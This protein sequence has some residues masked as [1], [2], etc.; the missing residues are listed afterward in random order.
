MENPKK[1]KKQQRRQRQ[2]KKKS[3][4]SQSKKKKKKKGDPAAGTS[5][6]VDIALATDIEFSINL[7]QKIRETDE[8]RDQR[9]KDK[10][11]WSQIPRPTTFRVRRYPVCTAAYPEEQEM[12]PPK[13]DTEAL[14]SWPAIGHTVTYIYGVH[15][16]DLGRVFKRRA[17]RKNIML[18]VVS[19]VGG[20]A[21]VDL[22]FPPLSRKDF[23]HMVDHEYEGSE[24]VLSL[25]EKN[26]GDEA[27]L[28]R[29][30]EI[31]AMVSNR[32]RKG[33][34]LDKIVPVWFL[35]W[36]FHWDH[37]RPNFLNFNSKFGVCSGIADKMRNK[38]STALGSLSGEG[39]SSHD[40]ELLNQSRRVTK[41]MEIV[42]ARNDLSLIQ[43]RTRDL[44]SVELACRRLFKPRFHPRQLRSPAP[45]Y[46][47][48]EEVEPPQAKEPSPSS[49]SSKEQDPL[50][51]YVED[52]QDELYTEIFILEKKVSRNKAD[53]RVVAKELQNMRLREIRMSRSP[54]FS[55]SPSFYSL[56]NSYSDLP[57]VSGE[58]D[59]DDDFH[60]E[61]ESIH[62]QR[63]QQQQQHEVPQAGT[64]PSS[65]SSDSSDSDDDDST[66]SETEREVERQRKRKRSEKKKKKKKKKEKI[67]RTDDPLRKTG[68]RS[69][70][71]RL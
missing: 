48:A 49:S 4:K 57:L 5:T 32:T 20:R 29:K 10:K 62:Y 31:V 13:G 24:D 17:S 59:D 39:N 3:G 37:V 68:R 1:G 64:P 30:K 67:F 58:D 41:S 23:Q 15:I 9:T 11:S 69:K 25:L 43:G 65:S 66:D 56:H 22:V 55:D 63:Q 7:P 54:S 45:E 44:I 6:M 46:E 36:M 60:E 33:W 19:K 12:P 53:L 40:R 51:K 42:A 26:K 38:M 16:L 52:L 8:Q 34:G 61:E 27:V 71:R 47:E 28:L 21:T 2:R 70:R 35:I 50:I 18:E 14:L